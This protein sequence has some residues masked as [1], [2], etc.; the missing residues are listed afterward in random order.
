MRLDWLADVL[1]SAGLDAYE[2][3]EA[4]PAVDAEARAII[5]DAMTSDDELPAA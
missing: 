1:R 3:P 4:D 2:M 5:R